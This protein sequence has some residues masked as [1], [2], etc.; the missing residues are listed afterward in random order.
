VIVLMLG[1]N[2]CNVEND[3][4]R[5]EEAFVREY[6]EFAKQLIGLVD[7][8]IRRLFVLPPPPLYPQ[9][10]KHSNVPTM[11]GACPL[12]LRNEVYPRLFPLIKEQL[13]LPNNNFVDS[14]DILGG[15]DHRREELFCMILDPVLKPDA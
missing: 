13:G 1:S 10:G 7:G 9:A 5:G 11:P 14:F 8:D 4:W 12:E 3:Y 6:V 15:S 2:D